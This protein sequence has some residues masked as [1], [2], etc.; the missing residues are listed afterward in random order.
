MMMKLGVLEMREAL[1]FD[2]ALRQPYV[3]F[4]VVVKVRD[5]LSAPDVYWSNAMWTIVAAIAGLALGMLLGTTL[6]VVAWLSAILEGLLTPLTVLFSSVPVVTVIPIVARLLG[7]DFTTVLAIVVIISFF[8]AFVFTT[9]GLR[10]LPPGSDD[11]FTVLGARTP[12]RLLRLALPAALPNWTVALRV[13]AG[14]AVLGAMVA[15]Y[16][17]GTAGLGY[18]FA[19]TKADFNM[20]RAFGATVVAMVVSMA[21][22]AAALA[23]ERWV[24]QRWA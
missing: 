12:A 15:E 16:L 7:Y 6:A 9:S 8:P 18:L 10:A 1:G 14:H 24:K 5:L 17:M 13:A 2:H 23:V 19:E 3:D 21:F 4:V 22:F 20:D 11:L